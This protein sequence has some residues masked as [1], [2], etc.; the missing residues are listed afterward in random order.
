MKT[1]I[2]NGLR[3]STEFVF[4]QT[5]PDLIEL[6]AIQLPNI[7]QFSVPCIPKPMLEK[8]KW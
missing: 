6:D 8:A 5:I 2:P 3:G 4:Q 7:L 1:K